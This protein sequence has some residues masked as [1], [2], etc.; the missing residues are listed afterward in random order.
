MIQLR[1][2]YSGALK[3]P[4]IGYRNYADQQH[5]TQGRNAQLQARASTD[6]VAGIHGRDAFPSRVQTL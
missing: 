6:F 3:R 1:D 2:D 5:Q 4:R